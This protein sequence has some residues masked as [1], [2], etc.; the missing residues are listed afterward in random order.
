[1][2]KTIL[3]IC[4]SLATCALVNA[5]GNENSKTE[6]T[7]EFKSVI[8]NG[9]FF[10]LGL[11]MGTSQYTT[12]NYKGTSVDWSNFKS[13]S[14]G[15]GF[16]FEIGNQWYLMKKE[17]FGIAL[18]V[19]WLQ[20]SYSPTVEYSNTEDVRNVFNKNIPTYGLQ[21]DYKLTSSNVVKGYYGEVKLLNIAPQITFAPTSTFGI[22]AYF[23]GGLSAYGGE[24]T[25]PTNNKNVGFGGPGYNL[26][27]GVRLRY[28]KF[29]LGFD[30]TMTKLQGDETI[31]GTLVEVKNKRDVKTPRFY[32]GMQF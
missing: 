10:N 27:P 6:A 3:L 9:F 22:D 16:G 25:D 28:K 17:K 23:S 21:T 11:G 8:D 5:N 24:L 19:T 20:A 31:V 2:K 15:S 7:Q 18:R 12:S 13:Q 32:L 1:M 29:A 14:L 30:Y 4:A 26:T